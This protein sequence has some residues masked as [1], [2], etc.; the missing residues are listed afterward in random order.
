[1]LI[2]DTEVDIQIVHGLLIF[3]H[4]LSGRVAGVVAYLL[5][6]PLHLGQLRLQNIV[7]LL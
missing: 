3:E 2:G 5:D 1:M 4:F 6:L 7:I